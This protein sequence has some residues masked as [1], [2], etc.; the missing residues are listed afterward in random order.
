MKQILILVLSII[1]SSA[2]VCKDEAQA[3]G[4]PRSGSFEISGTAQSYFLDILEDQARGYL[5]FVGLYQFGTNPWDTIIYQADYD[6]NM[7]KVVIYDIFCDYFS[8][9][10][11]LNA[12]FIYI[13]DKATKKIFEIDT[14]LAITRELSIS[15]GSGVDKQNL[16]LSNNYLFFSLNISSVIETCRWDMISSTIQ[17]LN[18]GVDSFTNFVPINDEIVFFGSVDTATDQY[19][20]IS[21]NFSDPSNLLWKKSILCPTTGCNTKNSPSIISQDKQ[22]I[23]TMILFEENFLFYKININD[24]T[25]QNSGFI[26]STSDYAHSYIMRE[27]NELIAIQISTNIVGR[28]RRLILVKADNTKIIKEYRSVNSQIY[29]VGRLVKDGAELMYHSGMISTNRTFFFGRST[30]NNIDQLSEFEIDT[31]FFTQIT[32][33]YQI[34]ST[35]S[36]PSLTSDSKSITVSNSASTSITATDNTSTTTP[37]F[38]TYVALWNEDHVQTVQSNSSVLLDFTWA[39][40][41]S[42]NYTGITFSLAQTGSNGIPEWVQLDA[43]I[44]ELHLNKTPKLEKPKTYYFSLQISFDAEVHFKQFEII[45]EQC[46]ITNCEICQLGNPNL[47]EVCE[48]G[49]QSSNE[50]KACIVVSAPAGTTEAATALIVASIVM[51][52]TASLLSLSSI[53]SIFSTMN[54]LQLAI[55]LPLVPEYFSAR[56]L[57]F[58]GGMG[59]TMFSFDFIKFSDI[60]LIL[61][62]TDW[63]SYPQ[64]DKYLN[65]LGMRSGS[66]VV[67]YLSLMAIIILLGA[68]HC[69]IFIIKKKAD[70][71]QSRRCKL[72]FNKLF[73]FFTF[74]IYIRIFIQAFAF[75]SLSIFSEIYALNLGSIVTKISFGLC[76]MFGICSSVL[77]LLSFYMYCKSFPQIDYENHWICIEY[78]NGI[79]P[80]KYSKLYSCIFLSLRL[81]L[82]L[83][84][85]FGESANSLCKS[86]YFSILN[87]G[88]CGYLIITIPFESYQDNIIEIINQILFCCLSIPLAWVNTESDWTSFYESYYISVL[89]ISPLIGGFVSFLFLINSFTKFLKKRTPPQ[90]PQSITPKTPSAPLPTPSANPPQSSIINSCSNSIQSHSNLNR[91]KHSKPQKLQKSHKVFPKPHL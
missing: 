68:I 17:T 14:N 7:I 58:L 70:I 39:C 24:G 6:L 2:N 62:L 19:Y 71:S 16:Q 88:Y 21:Y 36:N 69:C 65:S 79:K 13:P 86:I 78:F 3:Q 23:Y 90:H 51:T 12:D 1:V 27:F 66:S 60:P 30:T 74:N 89:M 73:K 33:N 29:V 34:S 52:S 38:N 75:T 15:F 5:Y 67:N 55:L 47:C 87:I 35:I 44:Q 25:P 37:S 40:A 80:K 76:I 50:N 42:S 82:I 53:N 4:S 48:S 84:L 41:Q 91:P 81:M 18:F 83:F 72:I 56:V 77:F 85:I 63:V 32:S 57:A 45:V 54:S 64:S 10:I 46:N 49:Y 59:F 28:Y 31:S 22:F 20:L 8:Y 9:D 61:K 11:S 26:W 43:D